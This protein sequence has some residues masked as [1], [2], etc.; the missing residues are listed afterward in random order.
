MYNLNPLGYKSESILWFTHVILSYLILPSSVYSCSCQWLIFCCDQK[1]SISSYSHRQKAANQTKA[2][3]AHLICQHNVI[4][5]SNHKI[6]VSTNWKR[7]KY[8]LIR[9]LIR[10]RHLK[11]SSVKK[12]K[13][14]IISKIRHPLTIY[15][16]LLDVN[17][18]DILSSSSSGLRSEM[19]KKKKMLILCH[20]K[21]AASNPGYTC[22]HTRGRGEVE[23]RAVHF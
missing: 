9:K 13:R 21:Y 4:K 19:E 15:N 1:L 14:D 20:K 3:C 23:H 10:N 2:W 12:K 5:W 22:A 16:Q 8:I 6:V 7:L 11:I 17:I 18:L